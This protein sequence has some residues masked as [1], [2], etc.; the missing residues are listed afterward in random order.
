[1]T[2]NYITGDATSPVGAKPIILVH[3][4]NDVGGWGAG[5]VL[6]ISKRWAAPESEFYK[7]HE[8]EKGFKLGNVQFVEVE[9]GLIVANM[10]GQRDIYPD[11]GIPPI[12]YDALQKCLS[13]VC[14][15]AKEIGASVHM[16]K[17]GAGLAGGEW[18]VIEEIIKE[19]LCDKDIS[20]TV[21]TLPSSES[22]LR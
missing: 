4:C 1:M 19:E 3:V 10:I 6:A 18:N 7:W 9:D 22:R 5:F 2:I 15:K 21:Y 14:K 8:S 17:I 13:K 11:K 16:P 20:V 12:R